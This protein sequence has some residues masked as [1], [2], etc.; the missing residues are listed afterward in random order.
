M[1]IGHVAVVLRIV[2]L[3]AGLVPALGLKRRDGLAA[4]LV[5]AGLGIEA[6]VEVL[7]LAQVAAEWWVPAN[8]FASSD[9]VI[10]AFVGVELLLRLA[11]YALIVVGLLRVMR[12][13]ST[14][15]GPPAPPG[16]PP[17]PPGPPGPGPYGSQAGPYGPT[18]V[19][20]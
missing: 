8:G 10:T 1:A 20:R 17:V 9:T 4:V 19:N 15:S 13:P 12:G 2:I 16:P 3:V 6:I 11:G 14:V 18:G 5:A 7:G